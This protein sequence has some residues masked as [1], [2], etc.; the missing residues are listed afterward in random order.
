MGM[1]WRREATCRS[2]VALL[3]ATL[4]LAV[5][6]SHAALEEVS[7]LVASDAARFDEFGWSVALSG[8][9]ALVG[10]PDDDIAGHD[11]GSAYVFVRS[12]T[13]WSQQA[14]LVAS[15]GGS[16]DNFGFSV[17]LSGDYALV[18]APN[19]RSPRPAY[20]FLRNGTSWSQQAKLVASDGAIYDRFGYSVALSGDYALVGARYDGGDTN[21]NS[22]SAYVFFRD[23]T[24]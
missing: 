5:R 15:D 14:K 9:Y 16:S 18:G 11:G 8:D 13:S 20:V 6:I 12:G 1:M 7:K 23:G 24:S 3:A 19:T 17:A 2:G 21:T 10:A 4:G 22:G